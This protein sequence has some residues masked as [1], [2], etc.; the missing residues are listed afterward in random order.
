MELIQETTNFKDYLESTWII[1]Y[2]HER[3]KKQAEVLKADLKDEIEIIKSVYHFVRDDIAHPS[4]SGG[5]LVTTTAPEV[6][7]HRLGLCYAKS[8]LLAALLRGL[9]IPCGICYQSLLLDEKN[10]ASGIILH[11]LNAVYLQT[12]KKWIRLDARGNKPGIDA[13]FSTTREKL[14]YHVRPERGEIDHPI[15]FAN[16][17]DTVVKALHS[18]DTI[19][20]L[21]Q[22]LPKNLSIDAAFQ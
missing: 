21:F 8:H 2:T 3:V 1:D 19:T 6:L 16:P 4:D 20:E 7:E 15:I 22:H 5:T 10:P 12:Q 14:A 13:Q 17:V 9:K 18:Y 11:A